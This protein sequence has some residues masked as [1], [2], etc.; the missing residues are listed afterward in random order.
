MEFTVGGQFVRQYNVDSSPGGAFGIDTV[1]DP[2][3]H[4]NY[5]A[6][7]DVANNLTV[8]HFGSP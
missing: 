7:D 4:F 1:S 6:I 3:V 8:T 2:E 5:A